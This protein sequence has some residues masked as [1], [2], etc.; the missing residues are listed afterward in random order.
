[1]GIHRRGPEPGLAMIFPPPAAAT[2][3]S[4]VTAG[5][6]GSILATVRPLRFDAGDLRM[7]DEHPVLALLLAQCRVGR[8]TALK[9]GFVGDIDALPEGTL[10]FAG[11]AR[12]NKRRAGAHRRHAA[13]RPYP[14][15]SGTHGIWSQ[16][17]DKDPRLSWLNYMSTVASKAARVV[18]AAREDGVARSV[19]SSDSAAPIPRQRSRLPMPPTLPA[20]M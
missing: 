14:A 3:T 10:A 1:M 20:V 7:L 6:A 12:R 8:W 2:A 19:P 4:V 13:H 16:P 17:R 11:P 15:Y 5:L 9:S 18:G